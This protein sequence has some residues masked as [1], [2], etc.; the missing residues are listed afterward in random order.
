M[1]DNHPDFLRSPKNILD[2][3]PRSSGIGVLGRQ[4]FRATTLEDQHEAVAEIVV[5][6]GAPRAVVVKFELRRT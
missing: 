1:T 3:D 5:H 2:P 4:G 6:D